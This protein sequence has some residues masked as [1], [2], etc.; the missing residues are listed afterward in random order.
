VIRFSLSRFGALIAA[1]A[2]SGAAEATELASSAS[3]WVVNRALVLD[4]GT[5]FGRNTL[6]TDPV[7]SRRAAGTWRLPHEGESWALPSGEQRSWTNAVADASGWFEGPAMR[8]GWAL[9]TI[10]V[11][12]PRIMVLNASGQTMGYVNGEPRAGDL[13]QY[14]YV[15]TPINRDFFASEA[16][17]AVVKRVPQRRLGQP[18]DLTGPLLLLASP[19]GAHMTGTTL[20]VDGGHSVSPL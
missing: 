6:F 13:Y 17:Q 7:E 9:M 18:A 4:T 8:G 20:V 11:P 19:A 12:E 10:E 1:L 15:E 2:L 16:G 14:G 5:K 3:E